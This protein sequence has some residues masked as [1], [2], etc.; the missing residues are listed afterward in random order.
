[1]KSSSS[2]GILAS[3][4]GLAVA[5]CTQPTSAAGSQASADE[6]TNG[7]ARTISLVANEG[8]PITLAYA[9]QQIQVDGDSTTHTASGVKITVGR[10]PNGAK[11]SAVI[12]DHCGD[13]RVGSAFELAATCTLAA[14]TPGTYVVS[15]NARNCK[16]AERADN[17]DSHFPDT[18]VD[19]S[20]VSGE[21]VRCSQEIAVVVN[22]KWLTDPI[23]GT[24]N[25]KFT[26]A[27][28]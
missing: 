24:H 28:Q 20:D 18:L 7:P 11:V 1:M 4:L 19:F 14:G 5:A 9:A 10:V 16:E 22:D 15:M 8:N 17:V 26:F 23:N 3:L 25:F 13:P 27:G 2:F 12:V 6:V 21:D